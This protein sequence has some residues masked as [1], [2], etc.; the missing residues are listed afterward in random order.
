MAGK[1]ASAERLVLC[2]ATALLAACSSTP[3]HSTGT[4]SAPDSGPRT[5]P[6]SASPYPCSYAARTS[7]GLFYKD[8]GPLEL[9]AGLE[10]IPDAS[11]KTEPL[12]RWANNPYTVLGQTFTPQ[13]TPGTLRER[14]IGSWYGR[15]FHGQK[16]SSGEPYNMFAMTAAHPTLPIPSYARVTNLKNGRS[17]IVRVN[18]R[19]PFLKGRVIDLSFLAACRLGYATNGSSELEVVSLTPGNANAVASVEKPATMARPVERPRPSALL[20]TPN[21]AFFLQLGAFSSRANAESFHA[22]LSREMDQEKS[23]RL[24]IQESGKMYRV[25]LGPFPDRSSALAMA[26]Q[27]TGSARQTAVIA[28]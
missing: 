10:S 6:G 25:R 16:T 3:R 12:H 26:E 1:N 17:V 5:V 18:D 8:D 24:V 19:G 23:A 4:A 27:L 21:N 20:A 9:P 11:P 13:K 2:L 14:G 7:G 22:H 15:K 28:R